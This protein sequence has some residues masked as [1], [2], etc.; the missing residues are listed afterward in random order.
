MIFGNSV[1]CT[2]VIVDFHR[3]TRGISHFFHSLHNTA[4]E[5]NNSGGAEEHMKRV[6]V[7]IDLLICI[8]SAQG[9]WQQAGFTGRDVECIAQHPRDTSIMLA[10]IVDSLFHSSDGGYTWSFINHFN[11]LPIYCLMYDLDYCDTVY[12]L[13]GNGTYSDGI[14]RSTDGG[15]SWAVLEWFLRPRCMTI[16]GE[17]TS[18]MLV[19]C[20]SSGIFKT[21]DGGSTWIPW[22][23]GLT[24]FHIYSLCFCNPFD[25]FPIIYTGTAHGLFCKSFDGWV[26]A[27]GIPVDLRVSSISYDPDQEI[28]FAAVTG[29]SWSDGIYRS[30]DY[31]YNWQVVDWLIYPSCVA[32]NPLWQDY[33]GDTCGVFAGDSGLGIKYSSDC[34]NTWQD[35]N[36]GLGNL[37][38]N[39]LSFHPQDSM[40]L[41]AATQGGLYRYEYGPGIAEGAVDELDHPGIRVPTLVRAGACITVHCSP[42][43]DV[44]PFSCWLRLYDATGRLRQIALLQNARTTLVPAEESGVYF[45]TV[46]EGK[47]HYRQ[48]IIVID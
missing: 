25:S 48:K 35:V 38:V 43:V 17:P 1:Q 3:Q 21:E 31:G 5:Y 15:Y 41:F 14:Y 9:Q 28:G 10:G 18:L 12:A 47:K 20:D 24:D 29:G 46:G 45:L 11:G 40:R 36:A 32:L 13:L 33:P 26:Q 22:N 34:G 6:F 44:E 39:A 30:T 23:D 37:Y 27:N 19:G 16:P 2:F 42:G 4:I 8:G 7:F